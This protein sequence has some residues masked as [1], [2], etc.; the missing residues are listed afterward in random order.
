MNCHKVIALWATVA[1]AP[2]LSAQALTVTPFALAGA[3]YTDSDLN[4]STSIYGDGLDGYEIGV[5]LTF[6]VRLNTRHELS[7]GTGLTEWTGNHSSTP[8]F[9]AEDSE[10]E[11]IPVLL[12]YCYHLPLDSKGR[13]T[14][15]FG[16]TAGFIHQ[17]LTI[18]T[19]NL[20]GLPPPLIGSDTQSDWLF[21]YGATVGLNAA[22]TTHWTVGISAQ[23]LKVEES[24]FTTF[25]G[26]G[27]FGK[28]ESQT[29]PS[30]TV[31][32]GYAW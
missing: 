28:F 20:G 19:T 3:T 1:I 21:A 25:G 9:A 32:A 24:E 15:F 27:P 7:I 22:V 16:P 17:K 13:Y 30:F 29:R 26:A 23:V 10:V 2:V 12:N 6:G 11:Q 18:T 5:G 4:S 14:L 8:G 31:L